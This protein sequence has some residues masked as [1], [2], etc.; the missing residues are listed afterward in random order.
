M[1]MTA[2][3]RPG[4]GSWNR[5][6]RVEAEIWERGQVNGTQGKVAEI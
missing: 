6:L 5:W 4:K 2:V 3:G 1:A